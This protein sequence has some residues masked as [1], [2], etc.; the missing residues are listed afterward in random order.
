MSVNGDFFV[1]IV[2]V[3]DECDIVYEVVIYYG[4]I[5]F[6]EGCFFKWFVCFLNIF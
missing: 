1:F 5:L 4:F 6:F 3:Y 2:I